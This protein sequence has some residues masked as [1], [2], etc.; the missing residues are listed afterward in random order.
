VITFETT[1]TPCLQDV[2][3][4]PAHGASRRGASQNVHSGE[5]QSAVERAVPPAGLRQHLNALALP[6]EPGDVLGRRDPNT[7]RGRRDR[8]GR[9][10]QVDVE[11]F[12]R[13]GYVVLRQAFS[14]RIAGACR[15]V[16]WEVLETRG[17]SR[18]DRRTW[19]TPSVRILC[20]DAE[21]FVEA[22]TSPVL[23]AA[24]DELI[25]PGRWTPRKKVGG[26]VPVRFP[27]EEWPGDTGYHIEGNWWGGTSTG[28]MCGLGAVG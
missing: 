15:D 25:G 6:A 16:I 1:S 17:L 7:R 28:R 22:A 9:L 24:Y 2:S 10:G 18:D 11:S 12:M 20:P 4:P 21:P 5:R 3:T 23:A 26:D 14:D 13:N 27:S 19:T 8:R